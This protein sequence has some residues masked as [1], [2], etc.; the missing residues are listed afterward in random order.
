MAIRAVAWAI[1]QDLGDV[2]AKLVLICLANYCDDK[3]WQSFPSQKTLAE[4]ATVSRRTIWEKLNLLEDAGLIKREP[5]RREDGGRTSDLITLTPLVNSATGGLQTAARGASQTVAKLNEPSKGT[6]SPKSPT[7]VGDLDQIEFNEFENAWQWSQ[8]N[9]RDLARSVWSK[10][11]GGNQ[12]AAVE[13][14]P[15]YVAD[16]KSGR[17]RSKRRLQPDKYLRSEMWKNC[18]SAVQ[19]AGQQVF[20]VQS[21]P[22]W[23]YA[24]TR[25]GQS[26]NARMMSCNPDTKQPERGWYFPANLFNPPDLPAA[27]AEVM[28]R[29]WWVIGGLENEERAA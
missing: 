11:D 25:H 13:Y 10:M 20:V 1:D 9:R 23:D 15:V 17:A 6:I 24:I 28:G 12:R 21:T 16:V 19:R 18:R 27:I 2:T 22:A 3:S 26:S 5:Q 14:V 29:D 7:D 8:N 4:D